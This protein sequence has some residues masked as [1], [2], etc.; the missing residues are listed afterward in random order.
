MSPPLAANV[1]YKNSSRMR[2]T[3]MSSYTKVEAS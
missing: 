1:K 2:G 3:L